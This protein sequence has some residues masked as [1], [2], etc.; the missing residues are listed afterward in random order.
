[1]TCPL[2]KE[3]NVHEFIFHTFSFSVMRGRM[4]DIFIFQSPIE[5]HLKSIQKSWKLTEIIWQQR[6]FSLSARHSPS[7]FQ[8]R[9]SSVPGAAASWTDTRLMTPLRT[10]R[11]RTLTYITKWIYCF[12]GRCVHTSSRRVV[13]FAAFFWVILSRHY[14][15]PVRCAALTWISVTCPKYINFMNISNSKHQPRLSSGDIIRSMSPVLASFLPAVTYQ[16]AYSRRLSIVN[17][18]RVSHGSSLLQVW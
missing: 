8:I 18:S 5:N 3:K 11:L 15:P 10:R 16:N 9:V 4:D 2:L 7:L 12:V 17:E 6:H 1:M 14:H 13:K